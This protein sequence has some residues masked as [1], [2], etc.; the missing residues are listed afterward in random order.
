MRLTMKVLT[1]IPFAVVASLALIVAAV[2]AVTG[3]DLPFGVAAGV[4]GAAMVLGTIYT[5]AT[6]RLQQ[7][8]REERQVSDGPEAHPRP[9][10]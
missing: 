2:A 4:R 8:R 10:R 7:R 6:I 5:V 1:S 9:R 3:K